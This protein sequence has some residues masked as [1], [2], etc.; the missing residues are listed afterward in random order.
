MMK[1]EAKL[2]YCPG[3]NIIISAHSEI[4]KQV[5]REVFR[6]EVYPLGDFQKKPW[7]EGIGLLI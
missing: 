3:R 2:Y 7:K 5:D 6:L 1:N 4:L